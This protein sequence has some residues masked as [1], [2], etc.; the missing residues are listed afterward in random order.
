MTKGNQI[1]HP[2]KLSDAQP[3][4]KWAGGKRQLLPEIRKLIPPKFNRYFEPFVGAG[5][6]LF[7]LKCETATINDFNTELINCYRVI[8]ESPAELINETLEY[9]NSKT[10]YYQLRDI[11]RN[12]QDFL[13]LS[14]IKRAARIIYLNK[15]CFN[16]LFRVN[17]KGQ[18]N[19]PFGNY[20]NPKIILEPI[21]YAVSDY[22]NNADVQIL[23][24]D[25]MQ[26]VASAKNGDFVYFDPPYDP[27][28]E[29][30]SFTGYSKNS[31]NKE[32][33]KRLKASC[34][35]LTSRGCHVLLSNSDTPFIRELYN[36]PKYEIIQVSASRNINSIGTS[37][38][39]I[40]EVLVQNR[41]QA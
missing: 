15:T 18:F 19:V 32:D 41:L 12:K 39:K 28:S 2:S 21:I 4:L 6:V 13:K 29:T 27:L 5:A 11:D 24:G 22:L 38:G 31:F 9:E 16:G 30:S 37:R 25:F 33:Q 17:S 34:D 20:A 35:D 8:K 1:P 23:E 40:S 10:F 7:D 3:F 26:A 14:P 36:D